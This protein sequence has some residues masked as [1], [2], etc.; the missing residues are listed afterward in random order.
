MP[1]KVY[2]QKVSHRG[3][4]RWHRAGHWEEEAH[5]SCVIAHK[6]LV[7]QGEANGKQVA[8]G[9]LRSAPQALEH[10]GGRISPGGSGRVSGRNISLAQILKIPRVFC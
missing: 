6:A 8:P 10:S 9:C 5:W 7:M 3:A 4:L 2:R 1:G